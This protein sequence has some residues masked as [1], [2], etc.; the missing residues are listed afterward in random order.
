MRNVLDTLTLA[1]SIVTPVSD[2]EG[3]S[4]NVK[5]LSIIPISIYFAT[6]LH[7]GIP[8][9]HAYFISFFVRLLPLSLPIGQITTATF[10]PT[11]KDY[12]ALT[13]WRLTQKP[14]DPGDGPRVTTFQPSQV[15]LQIPNTRE[16]IRVRHRV[17]PLEHLLNLQLPSRQRRPSPLHTTRVTPPCPYLDLLRRN[18]MED[19]PHEDLQTTRPDPQA[20]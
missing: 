17:Y 3:A 10:S 12:L 1:L 2:R 11:L 14:S 16:P 4:A 5:S 18:Q 20:G 7:T 8:C 19:G 13:V 6:K 9:A 15:S